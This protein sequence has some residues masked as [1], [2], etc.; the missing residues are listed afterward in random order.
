MYMSSS[1]IEVRVVDRAGTIILNRPDFGNALTRSMVPQI[2]EALD[3]LYLEKRARSIIITGAGND[4]CVGADLHE[5]QGDC[6]NNDAEEQWGEDAADFRELLVRMLEITK[7]IIAAVNGAAL[8]AGAALVA[9]ADIVVASNSAAFGVPDARQGMVAG[10]AAPLLCFRIGA[11]QGARLLLTGQTIGAAE[12]HRLGVFHELTAP[13]TVWAR[14]MQLANDCA[15]GAPEAVQ[16]TKRLLNE[17]LGEN[18]STQLS[19][20]A[21][22]VATARTT[23]AAQEG[24]SATLAGRLPKW[25]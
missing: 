21:I 25:Q 22:M 6:E 11:G 5:M 8:A 18:L 7:P 4:F 14:A 23:E 17:T 13:D 1:A 12:A 9:A 24:I 19:A 10:L 15:A 2:V 20:G 3:D 16:L